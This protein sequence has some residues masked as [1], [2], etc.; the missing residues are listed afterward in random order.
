MKLKVFFLF[1]CVCF[2]YS[3]SYDNEESLFPD[4][5]CETKNVTYSKFVSNYV[6]KLCVG[7]H[8]SASPSG[9]IVLDNYNAVKKYVDNGRFIGSIRH[10]N[11]YE[12]MPQSMP[13]SPKCDID[14]LEAW[15]ASGAPNN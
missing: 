8:S 7:C 2:I 9:G 4:V 14:K 10:D 11:G 3:C 15:I 6:N 13:K 12:R 5:T 1:A